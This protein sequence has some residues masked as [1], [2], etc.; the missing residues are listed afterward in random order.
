MD[1]GFSSDTA[2]ATSR[3]WGRRR[4][5]RRWFWPRR[6]V[7]ASGNVHSQ[8]DRRRKN[9]HATARGEDRSTSEIEIG[10]STRLEWWVIYSVERLFGLFGATHSV[11][12]FL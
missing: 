6:S 2:A 10:I 11:R 8:V 7:G 5:W 1:L 4:R 9:R 12:F 3:G